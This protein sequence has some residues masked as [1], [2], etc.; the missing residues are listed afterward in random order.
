[1]D[2]QAEMVG[3]AVG[4]GFAAIIATV[5]GFV[6]FGWS[7][8]AFRS[9]PLAILVAY[10]SVAVALMAFAVI[11]VRRGRKMMKALG[12]SRSDFWQKRRKAFGIVVALE[13]VSCIIVLVLV[14]VF[15][16]PNW[17]AVGI[18]LVVGLHFIALGSIFAPRGRL[19]YWV[20]GLMVGWDILTVTALRSWNPT[21]SAA[22]AAGMILW[23]ATIY[24]LMLS[25]RIVPRERP[26]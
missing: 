14:V 7:F 4:L 3:A 12:A 25:L 26:V 13:I 21:A 6:W 18:S 19:W 9:P 20:G 16:R 2:D 5:A 23:A 8:S 10:F 15:H 24:L 1:M 11:A 17:T 22:I